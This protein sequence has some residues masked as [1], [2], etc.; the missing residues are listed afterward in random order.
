MSALALIVILFIPPVWG[1]LL[2]LVII[3]KLPNSS[4]SSLNSL[5]DYSELLELERFRSTS[6]VIGLR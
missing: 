2:K 4:D 1:N 3:G 6:S 5:G